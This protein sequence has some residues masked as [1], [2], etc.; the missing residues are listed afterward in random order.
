MPL[1]IIKYGIM[2]VGVVGLFVALIALR[3]SPATASHRTAEFCQA[4]ILAKETTMFKSV[5]PFVND[6]KVQSK[7]DQLPF[8]FLGFKSA[9][10]EVTLRTRI[11]ASLC[12]QTLYKTVSGMMNCSK[13]I[14]LL[15]PRQEL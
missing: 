4:M 11:W 1:Q 12:A 15:Y 14:K 8:Y 3:M 5:N 7:A 10:P 2:Y 6:E 13:A 9:A